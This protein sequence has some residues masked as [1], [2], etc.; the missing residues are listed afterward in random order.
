[1]ANFQLTQTGAQVQADLNKVE[2]LAEIK[3]VG[4]GLTLSSSGELS[5][6][7]GGGGLSFGTVY[8]HLE[9][10][11]ATSNNFILKY[12][13]GTTANNWSMYE[14]GPTAVVKKLDTTGPFRFEFKQTSSIIKGV[15]ILYGTG[16]SS[17]DYLPFVSTGNSVQPIVVFKNKSEVNG[18]YISVSMF[19]LIGTSVGKDLHIYYF[20]NG[21]E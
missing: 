1:M 8:L 9:A 3:T 11:Y 4:S 2:S 7:G 18:D 16:S 19:N 21:T 14:P 6:S 12:A 17:D 15:T 10:T 13:D 5:S 20:D